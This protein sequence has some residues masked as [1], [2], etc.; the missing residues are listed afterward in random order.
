M[1]MS[2]IRILVVD[3]E[4]MVRLNL[5]AFLEDEG[6]EVTAAVDGEEALKMLEAG[7]ADVGIV[8]MRLPGIDGNRVILRAHKIRPNMKFLVHTG[9]TSYTVPSDIRNLGIC[10]EHVFLKP[11]EDMKVMTRAIY[12]LLA[13]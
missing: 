9:S 3:D 7:S 1:G 6:F 2:A 12:Q 8:D 4:E 11:I 5:V 13:E 10:E